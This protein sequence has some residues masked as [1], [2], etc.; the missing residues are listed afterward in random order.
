MIDNDGEKKLN[1]DIKDIFNA[2]QTDICAITFKNNKSLKISNIDDLLDIKWNIMKL[3]CGQKKYNNKYEAFFKNE[4]NKQYVNGFTFANKVSAILFL[5]MIGEHLGKSSLETEKLKVDDA[6]DKLKNTNDKVKL[7]ANDDLI[8]VFRAI[9]IFIQDKFYID[10]VFKNN[11]FMSGLLKTFFGENKEQDFIFLLNN[12]GRIDCDGDG[13]FLA[14]KNALSDC[15]VKINNGEFCFESKTKPGETDKQNTEQEE[16]KYRTSSDTSNLDTEPYTERELS[17]KKLFLLMLTTVC[18]A[19][20]IASI[21]DIIFSF[22]ALAKFLSI[23]LIIITLAIFI[24][25]WVISVKYD[26]INLPKCLGGN[27]SF[28]DVYEDIPDMEKSEPE[29]NEEEY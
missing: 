11:E 24:V 4:N 15:N 14:F 2:N 17:W 6:I 21:I 13:L 22:L 27:K 26:V 8:K 9:C 7:Q 16:S 23:I 18:F 1:N 19:L 5:S 3:I 29:I 28:L 12:I 20:V 25:S 10:D